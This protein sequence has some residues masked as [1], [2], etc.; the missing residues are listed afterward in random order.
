MISWRGDKGIGL[1]RSEWFMADEPRANA[2]G[3]RPIQAVPALKGPQ[4]AFCAFSGPMK[5]MKLL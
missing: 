5:W 4:Q 2:L 3:T 1:Q